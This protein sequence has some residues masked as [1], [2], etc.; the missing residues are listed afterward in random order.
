[1]K[2]SISLLFLCCSILLFGQVEESAPKNQ[3]IK[4]IQQALIVKG[5]FV[6][7]AGAN[8]IMNAETRAALIAFEKDKGLPSSC[9]KLHTLHALGLTEDYDDF[10]LAFNKIKFINQTL[11]LAGYDVGPTT[12]PGELNLKSEKAIA[13]FLGKNGIPANSSSSIMDAIFVLRNQLNKERNYIGS[14]KLNKSFFA[15]LNQALAGRGYS[16]GTACPPEFLNAPLRNIIIQFQK[17]NNLPVGNLNM[18][19]LKALGVYP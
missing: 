12:N 4:L 1:V 6:G 11:S 15:K 18:E 19:T 10:E 14:I 16:Y 2:L 13:E 7:S 5:Y 9:Y 8:N 17:D 3:R